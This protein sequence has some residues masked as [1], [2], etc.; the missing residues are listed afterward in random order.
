MV[1]AHFVNGVDPGTFQDTLTA[2]LA[3]NKLMELVLSLKPD[4]QRI[5]NNILSNSPPMNS[6]PSHNTEPNSPLPQEDASEVSD[7]EDEE[8]EEESSSPVSDSSIPCAQR[9]RKNKKKKKQV[10]A[11]LEYSSVPPSAHCETPSPKG[12]SPFK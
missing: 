7:A 5:L 6:P 1:H 2:F 10:S 12:F 3:A 4:S 8:E 11:R 9:E